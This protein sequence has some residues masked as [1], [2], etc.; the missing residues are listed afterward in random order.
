MIMSLWRHH[1]SSLKHVW[2]TLKLT[3]DPCLNDHRHKSMFWFYWNERGFLKFNHVQIDA[4]APLSIVQY[5]K[6]W[7]FRVQVFFENFTFFSSNAKN[8]WSLKFQWFF[9]RFRPFSCIFLGV[10]RVFAVFCLHCFFADS[11]KIHV[12]KIFTRQ[13]ANNSCTR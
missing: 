1:V 11:R 8:A 13:N 10:F 7:I 2:L 6:A 4:L 3:H 9:Y 5:C 12:A